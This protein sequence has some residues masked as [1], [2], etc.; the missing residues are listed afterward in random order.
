M[1]VRVRPRAVFPFVPVILSVV[2][3]AS[4]IR[5]KSNDLVENVTGY[6]SLSQF[7]VFAQCDI[8]LPQLSLYYKR[9]TLL[10][11]LAINRRPK[12]LSFAPTF[13]LASIS[14]SASLTE[15]EY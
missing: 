12:T 10:H 14:R 9:N 6:K 2:L 3:V 8:K 1:K 11:H 13:V 4:L 7:P 5:L 15:I